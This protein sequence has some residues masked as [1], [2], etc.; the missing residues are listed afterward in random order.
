MEKMKEKVKAYGFYT[1]VFHYGCFIGGK[2]L[3]WFLLVIM[4]L[5]Q[6][7]FK[8]KKNNFRFR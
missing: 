1:P 7:S 5:L 4:L 2:A 3:S 8:E 6:G